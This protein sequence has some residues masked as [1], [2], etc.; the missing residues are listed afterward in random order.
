[1]R[2]LLRRLV[3]TILTWAVSPF[4]LGGLCIILA[5]LLSLALAQRRGFQRDRLKVRAEFET[6][7]REVKA[8]VRVILPIFKEPLYSEV[9]PQEDAPFTQIVWR[10]RLDTHSSMP[11]SLQGSSLIF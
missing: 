7:R 6:F 8:K 10:Y 5:F 9:H 11:P 1:M 3:D 4:V 2:R